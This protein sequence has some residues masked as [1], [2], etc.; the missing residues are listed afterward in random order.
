[1]DFGV[2]QKE[3]VPHE[4]LGEEFQQLSSFQITPFGRGLLEAINGALKQDS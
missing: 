1:V 2:L 4:I 3:Y